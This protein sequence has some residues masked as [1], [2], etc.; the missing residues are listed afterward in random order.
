MPTAAFRRLVSQRPPTHAP[1]SMVRPPSLLLCMAALAT[2]TLATAA[3]ADEY[4]E[5][6]RLVS[7]RQWAEAVYKAGRGTNLERVAAQDVELQ[8]ALAL[9]TEAYDQKLL[10]INLLRV[11][12]TLRE[13]LLDEP[14]TQPSRKAE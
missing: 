14:T 11:T 5:V 8:A 2:L 1:T 3:R 9:A 7:S 4:A 13:T 12:G 10:R 6:D